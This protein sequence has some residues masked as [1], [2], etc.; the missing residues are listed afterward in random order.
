M[1]SR[2]PGR[3]AMDGAAGGTVRLWDRITERLKRWQADGRPSA[4]RMRLHVG[5]AGQRLTWA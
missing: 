1:G 3:L 2:F 5:P 4:D